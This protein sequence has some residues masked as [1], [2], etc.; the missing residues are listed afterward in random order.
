MTIS[1][2]FCSTIKKS[3]YEFIFQFS[4]IKEYDSGRVIQGNGETYHLFKHSQFSASCSSVLV[5]F[6]KNEKEGPFI[7]FIPRFEPLDSQ[8]STLSDAL[9]EEVT[10]IKLN[11][12]EMF[13][14]ILNRST[15]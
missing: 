12:F 5:G 15:N 13:K 9:L 6:S 7:S 10:L 4:S 8:Y 2:N 1:P 11:V 3:F 14:Q